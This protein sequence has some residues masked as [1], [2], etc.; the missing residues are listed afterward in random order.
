MFGIP[1]SYLTLR[2]S[3]SVFGLQW[4]LHFKRKLTKPKMYREVRLVIK[5]LDTIFKA[6][7]L[8]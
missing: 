1:A 2:V 5:V 8:I 7:H 4:I 3:S 6:G